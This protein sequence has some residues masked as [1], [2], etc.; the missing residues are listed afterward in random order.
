MS[1]ANVGLSSFYYFIYTV[2]L[3]VDFCFIYKMLLSPNEILQDEDI[4]GTTTPF[5]FFI[6]H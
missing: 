5:T 3:K 1:N 2:G 6:K 4:S